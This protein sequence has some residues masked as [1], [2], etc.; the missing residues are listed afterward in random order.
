M[1]KCMSS[2]DQSQRTVEYLVTSKRIHNLTGRW[3][4]HSTT[5][6]DSPLVKINVV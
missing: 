4:A 2:N 1:S 5:S 6:D 3:K